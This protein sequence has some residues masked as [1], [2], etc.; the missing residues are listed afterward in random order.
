MSCAKSGLSLQ[1]LTDGP[2]NGSK[3][4]LSQFERG[5]SLPSLVAL[6]GIAERLELDIIDL[7]NFPERGARNEL[8]ELTRGM[9][10]RELKQVLRRAYEMDRK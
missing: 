6:A 10:D 4:Y 2:D 7:V 1:A 3:G 5:P 8:L 9:N